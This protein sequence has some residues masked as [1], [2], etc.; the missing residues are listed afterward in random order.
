MSNLL[1]NMRDQHFVLFEQLGID[2]LFE[3]DKYSAFSKDDVLMMLNEAEKLSV[4]VLAPINAE[5][6]H[7][8]CTFKDG[9]VTVPEGFHNAFKLFVEAGWLC[10]MRSPEVGGQG[11]PAVMSNACME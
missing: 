8:G 4:N 11:M 3:T 7:Q 9:K 6:D 5:G 1:V 2:K 10:C